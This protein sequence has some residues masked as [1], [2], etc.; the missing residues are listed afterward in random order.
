MKE[1][2]S[3]ERAGRERERAAQAER[4]RQAD[5]AAAHEKALIAAR[6][7]LERAV[8]AVRQA[9]QVG[10]GRVAADD[11]WKVAKARLIELETGVAPSWAPKPAAPTETDAELGE[12]TGEPTDIPQE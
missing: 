8:E 12:D 11:A 10:K 3:A 1:S 5:E 4:V 2:A 9:K 6:R 7:D